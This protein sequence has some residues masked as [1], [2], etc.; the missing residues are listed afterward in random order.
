V[1]VLR[2]RA[3]DALQGLGPSVPEDRIVVTLL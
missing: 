2:S 1:S 3:A